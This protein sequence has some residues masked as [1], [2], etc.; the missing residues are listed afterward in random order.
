MNFGSSFSAAS[1]FYNSRTAAAELTAKVGQFNE[2]I[3]LQASEKNQA[4][5]MGMIENRLKALLTECQALAQMVTSLFNNV[6][7]S[8]GTSYSVNG[9]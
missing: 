3:A 2:Q 1:Q 8:A 5:D 7:A 9:T 4:A 6:H